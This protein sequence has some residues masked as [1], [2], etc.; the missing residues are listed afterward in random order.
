MD[1][2]K[3]FLIEEIRT[4]ILNKI[5]DDELI[6]YNKKH[7]RLMNGVYICY[8]CSITMV[9]KDKLI[10]YRVNHPYTWEEC[11]YCKKILYFKPEASSIYEIEEKYMSEINFTSGDR[12]ILLYYILLNA[13][14]VSKS[15]IFYILKNWLPHLIDFAWLII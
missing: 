5:D 10:W 15:F 3:R 8:K 7:A 12:L 4:I 14:V 2:E 1:Y 6:K 9:E 13:D 11:F